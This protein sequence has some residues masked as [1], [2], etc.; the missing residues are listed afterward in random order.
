M[1][2]TGTTS[3]YVVNEKFL[4]DIHV[5]DQVMNL[6]TNVGSKVIKL[7]GELPGAGL[8]W[9]DKDGIENVLSFKKLSDMYRITI[10]KAIE[11]AF[12]VHMKHE[13]VK[14]VLTYDGLYVATPSD[15]LL[16]NISDSKNQIMRNLRT[17]SEN[18]K[19]FSDR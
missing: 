15:K 8:V 10:D 9:N 11:N 14:F 19:G 2:D 13:I 16:K 7:R 18:K 6:S 12:N 5:S 1:L 4:K 17:L 3:H